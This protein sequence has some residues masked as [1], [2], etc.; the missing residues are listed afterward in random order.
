M[1]MS[2]TRPFD[3]HHSSDLETLCVVAGEIGFFQALPGHPLER[4]EPVLLGQLPCDL[5]VL[6]ADLGVQV[7]YRLAPRPA[8]PG[9][10]QLLAQALAYTYPRARS[11]Q[12]GQPRPAPVDQRVQLGADGAASILYPLKDGVAPG[13]DREETLALIRGDR[14][15]V[16]TKTFSSGIDPIA[17]ALFNQAST[18][19]IVWD[20]AGC[21]PIASVWPP[22]VFLEPGVH[23]IARS[24]PRTALLA[25]LSASSAGPDDRRA[26]RDALRR[27]FGGSEP[28]AQPITA[29]M[30]NSFA[31]Q[32]KASCDDRALWKVI[33]VGLAMVENAFDLHGLAI[34]LWRELVPSRDEHGTP[35]WTG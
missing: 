12:P 3:W 32:L 7:R 19:S 1:T 2:S 21:P 8:G 13:F 10:P 26:L 17:W 25:A 16:I 18:Q 28:L 34:V 35:P 33:D 30:K 31:D 14:V 11:D 29:A 5:A 24:G 23:G 6:I 9:D 20:P 27:L 15:V 22:G 4:T